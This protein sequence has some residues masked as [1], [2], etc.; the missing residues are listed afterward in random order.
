MFDNHLEY[1]DDLSLLLL[2]KHS[3]LIGYLVHSPLELQDYFN[4]H[5]IYLIRL[6]D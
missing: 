4:F 2:A 5:D 3:P 6:I 1:V